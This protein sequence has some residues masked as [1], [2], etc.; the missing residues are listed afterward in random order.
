M[1]GWLA[2]GYGQT[3]R[4]SDALNILGELKEQSRNSFVDP[5]HF[6]VAYFAVGDKDQAFRWMERAYEERSYFMTTLKLPIWDIIDPTIRRDPRFQ[7]IYTKVGL[8]P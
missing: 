3:G 4:R 5:T 2:I 7:A 1:E 6:A 8:P